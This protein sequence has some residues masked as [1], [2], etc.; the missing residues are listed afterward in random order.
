MGMTRDGTLVVWMVRS[1]RSVF[2]FRIFY[3]S[4]EVICFSLNLQV[5]SIFWNFLERA[6]FI[7]VCYLQT[8]R[9]IDDK[10]TDAKIKT[11]TIILYGN[12][13]VYQ[14]INVNLA[15]VQKLRQER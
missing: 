5:F 11:A 8:Y 3:E 2:C 7:N 12:V 1:V 4:H 14:N 13:N 15:D 6:G 9:N 10:F